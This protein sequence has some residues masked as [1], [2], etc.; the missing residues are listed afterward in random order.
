MKLQRP[1]DSN[2]ATGT[3]REPPDIERN[4]IS[5]ISGIWRGEFMTSAL[6]ISS[7]M[8]SP[9]IGS[10]AELCSK[11]DGE[12]VVKKAADLTWLEDFSE[13]HRHS[14]QRVFRDVD[15]ERVH[16][17]LPIQDGI[18][19]Q[20]MQFKNLYVQH[21]LYRLKD[22]VDLDRLENAWKQ[23]FLQQEVLRYASSLSLSGI[24][25]TIC[26]CFF[27]KCCVR[28]RTGHLDRIPPPS[29]PPGY[30]EIPSSLADVIHTTMPHRLRQY[31]EAIYPV[32]PGIEWMIGAWQ[33]SGGCRYQHAFVQRVRGRV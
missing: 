31:I 29:P 8:Q 10:I 13:K 14:I 30:M 23:V 4:V 1:G 9:S 16:P 24:S 22:G 15:V 3:V 7:I 6:S 32:S 5:I 18:L 19:A 12:D 11:S 21:F 2:H 25:E 26:S 28:S 33:N 20:S 17:T 27:S